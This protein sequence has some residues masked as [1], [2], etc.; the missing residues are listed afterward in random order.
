VY[1]ADRK[2][3]EILEGYDTWGE[4]LA[5]RKGGVGDLTPHE[6][7]NRFQLWFGIEGECLTERRRRQR[8][9]R[10]AGQNVQ[11]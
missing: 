11:R 5:D 6:E 9:M 3:G 7:G 4:V 1:I 8:T 10:V 2:E